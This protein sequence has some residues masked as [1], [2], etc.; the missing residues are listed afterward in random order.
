MRGLSLGAI[1]YIEKPFLIPQLVQ[2]IDSVLLSYKKQ[3]VALIRRASKLLSIEYEERGK[4]ISER[5]VSDYSANC[6]RYGL[7]AREIEIVNLL[8]TGQ[9]YKIIGHTLN[10]S[11]NTVAKHMSNIFQKVA[12]SNKVELVNKLHEPSRSPQDT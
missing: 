9:P 7:T 1:D 10:I 6:K 4:T 11:V 8:I 2:K 5:I 12:A 3:Q